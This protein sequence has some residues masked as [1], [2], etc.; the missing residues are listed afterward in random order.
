MTTD[1]VALD[2]ETTGLNSSVDA[3]TEIGAAKFNLQG[4]AIES[5]Q[6]FV[7][8]NRSI[9]QAIEQLTGITNKDVENAPQISDVLTPL[10]NFIGDAAIVGQN[11]KFDLAFLANASIEFPNIN[12]DTW[13]LSSILF[14]R[15]SHLDLSSLA[16]LVGVEHNSAHRAL[17]DAA[18]TRDVFLKLLELLK[19]SPEEL[20]SQFYFMAKSAEWNL[21]TLIE[22]IIV[23]DDTLKSVVHSDQKTRNDF[24]V[25]VA[26]STSDILDPIEEIKHV[27]TADIEAVFSSFQSSAELLP[28]YE[29]REGQYLMSDVFA[30]HLAYG[31][32][33]L[34][35][36]GTGTGKSLAYLIPALIHAGRNN[37]RVVISTHT[38][39][40]QDQLMDQE[41][42]LAIKGI[43]LSELDDIDEL[44]FTELKGRSNYLCLERWQEAI[45]QNHSLNQV[46]ARLFGRIANWIPTTETGDLSELYITSEERPTWNKIS[47]EG[48]DCLQR[49]CDYVKKGQCFIARAKQRAEGSHL[50]V[51][52]HALL[53][54][55]LIHDEQLLPSFDHLVVDEV[56]RLEEVTTQQFGSN[57]DPRS[58]REF[59]IE[60]NSK[61]VTD[62]FSL[63][64]I[65]RD[66]TKNIKNIASIDKNLFDARYERIYATTEEFLKIIKAYIQQIRKFARDHYENEKRPRRFDLVLSKVNRSYSDW[67]E[68]EEKTIELDVTL[69]FL[70]KNLQEIDGIINLSQNEINNY[71]SVLVQLRKIISIVNDYRFCI[72]RTILNQVPDDIVWISIGD[73]EVKLKSAPLDVAP[74]LDE[75]L[76]TNL[77][78]ILGTSA[79]IRA[80]DSFNITANRIGFSEVDTFE[81]ES[82]FNYKDQVLVLVIDD[83]P[84]PNHIDYQVELCHLISEAT[85][86]AKGRTLT[87]FTSHNSLRNTANILRTEL[88]SNNLNL[89]AQGLDGSPRR[90]IR[91]LE[92]DPASVI[93][94]TSAFWEG[95]DI[96]GD[97]L[98]QMILTRLPFSVPSDPIFMGRAEQYQDPFREYTLPQAILKFRQG[99]GRLI[100]RSTD[101]GIFI[102]ADSRISNRSYGSIFLD[103]LPNPDIRQITIND[104]SSVVNE[105]LF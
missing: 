6:T 38:I 101:R 93:F 9:P 61:D 97:T 23:D 70:C 29:I 92:E 100:R 40:L 20:L 90:L 3:I 47:A 94:G 15:A 67:I 76:F 17:A 84:D 69:E 16:E 56:H 12:Y 49:A 88:S 35:E 58:L 65:L 2:L 57:F 96:P 79:T 4:D 37:D 75:S 27:K 28:Y 8:P 72:D 32:Q 44:N 86:A 51:V 82:P 68:I 41:I 14:P 39:N 64:N 104:V 5:F 13:E 30:K 95:V 46:E 85:M 10:I 62:V 71:N 89:L 77:H 59:F 83:I 24:F 36:A 87:L 91:R 25:P 54:S 98:S 7:N 81:I 21:T 73:G 50:V 66:V 33:L 78:S 53:I 105:W 1:F 18:V 52:N 99:F 34:I 19:S 63:D 22:D 103:A 45:E 43:N 74:I 55:N 48:S 31:G 42:P 80:N 11:I 60:L 26:A 102:I